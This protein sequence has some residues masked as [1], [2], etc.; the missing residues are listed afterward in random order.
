MDAVS[1]WS[2]LVAGC[3]CWLAAWLRFL[4]NGVV[5]STPAF[6]FL[7]PFVFFWLLALC[8]FHRSLV[9][10]LLVSLRA[11]LMLRR[12]RLLFFWCSFGSFWVGLGVCVVPCLLVL[13]CMSVWLG[14]CAPVLLVALF[15]CARWPVYGWVFFCG[16]VAGLRLCVSASVFFFAGFAWVLRVVLCAF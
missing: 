8:V 12:L 6:V 5:G 14:A 7:W 13:V 4:A 16:L 15:L 11:W 3:R 9:L 1:R 10:W 2:L